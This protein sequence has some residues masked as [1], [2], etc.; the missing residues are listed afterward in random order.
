M[1]PG[2]GEVVKPSVIHGVEVRPLNRAILPMLTCAA[3]LRV[4]TVEE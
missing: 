3:L 4:R 2:G 1:M